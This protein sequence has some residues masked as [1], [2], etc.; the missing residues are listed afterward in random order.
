MA[1]RLQKDL[2]FENI[3]SLTMLAVLHPG[4]DRRLLDLYQAFNLHAPRD[5]KWHIVGGPGTRQIKDTGVRL[6]ISFKFEVNKGV[7]FDTFEL[8]GHIEKAVPIDES[9]TE[10]LVVVTGTLWRWVV[11]YDEL[12]KAEKVAIPC[13][14]NSHTR[15]GFGLVP[16]TVSY[17][18]NE[19][20]I[21]EM[22]EE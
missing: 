13:Y 5:K 22:R 18:V 7:D 10:W 20:T 14:Y 1:S 6:Q 11:G 3:T 8:V 15:T 21:N 9:T 16:V 17:E 4:W 12:N 2:Q 19:I